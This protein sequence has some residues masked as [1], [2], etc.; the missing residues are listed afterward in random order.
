MK[1]ISTTLRKI[2]NLCVLRFSPFSFP[3]CRFRGT[4][5]KGY[6]VNKPPSLDEIAALWGSA[7]HLQKRAALFALQ[8]DSPAAADPIAMP[9]EVLTRK[10]AAARFHRHPSFID[11]AR[12]QGLLPPVRLKGRKRGCGF[13][14]SDVARLMDTSGAV[15]K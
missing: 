6:P 2:I 15:A 14:A 12:R 1:E 9:D 4:P 8:T 10:E 13:R 5:A 7:S 11:R 3:V